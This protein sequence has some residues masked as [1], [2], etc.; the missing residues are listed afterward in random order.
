MRGQHN[1]TSPHDRSP[2]EIMNTVDIHQHNT[3][4]IQQAYSQHHFK[5]M[6][7]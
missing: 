6:E 4:N 2:G 1:P 3:L 5:Q 7:T